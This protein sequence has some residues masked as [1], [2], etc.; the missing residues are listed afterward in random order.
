MIHW[1]RLILVSLALAGL[2]S[3]S[4]GAAFATKAQHHHHCEGMM[5]DQN[6]PSDD[7]GS[8]PA[9]CI[10]SA[11]AFVQPTF[12]PQASLPSAVGDTQVG[13]LLRDDLSRS[14]VRPPPGLRPPIA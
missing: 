11:C 6:C 13:Q 7:L 3:A 9:C 5:D 12:S 14:G 8:L 1:I 10:A 2:L 4:G